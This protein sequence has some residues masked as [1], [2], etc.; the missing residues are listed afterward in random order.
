MSL[1]IKTRALALAFNAISRKPIRFRST[2]NP[3]DISA[4]CQAAV[5][6]STKLPWITSISPTTSG[7]CPILDRTSEKRPWR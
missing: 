5:S 4:M 1:Q 7:T 2:S 3:S 6:L